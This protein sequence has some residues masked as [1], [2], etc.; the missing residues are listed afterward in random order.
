MD[1]LPGH[2]K[3]RT[4]LSGTENN[5]PTNQGTAF[6]KTGGWKTADTMRGNY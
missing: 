3:Q 5:S 6:G 4:V 1:S 2:A